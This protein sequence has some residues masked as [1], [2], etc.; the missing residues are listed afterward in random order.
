M[1]SDSTVG[2]GDAARILST[3]PR[4]L[5]YYEQRGVIRPTEVRESGHRRY[6]R[7][8]LDRA[9]RV[10]RLRE[11]GVPIDAA[12][13]AV[14]GDPATLIGILTSQAAALDAHLA[15]L[16]DLRARLG[17]LLSH[18]GD[19]GPDYLDESLG[20][21]KELSMKI[22]LSQIYTRAGDHGTTDLADGARVEKTDPLLDAIGDVDELI[23]AIGVAVAASPDVPVE[24]LRTIQNELFD[25]GADIARI[26]R[27]E[28]SASTPPLVT[29]ANIRRL[30]H[31]CDELNADLVPPASFVLPGGDPLSA[32]L[33]HARAVCRRAERHC[34]AVG[35]SP[36][37]PARYLNR[38]SDLLFIMARTA[39]RDGEPTWTPRRP[40]SRDA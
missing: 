38:L 15:Q 8:T 32:A 24:E 30:E 31:R 4:T 26:D 10:L 7:A 20:L 34:W 33:H 6:D 39:E 27:D 14:D 1:A 28:R 11:F 29:E 23:T 9:R 22:V 19:A 3:T 25:L 35:D 16:G 40:A 36:T 37:V 17:V 18:R 12:A 13:A 2:I 21:L 5:R